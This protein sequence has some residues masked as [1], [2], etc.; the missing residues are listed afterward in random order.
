M[1]SKSAAH[2]RAGVAKTSLSGT[3][4]IAPELRLGPDDLERIH[5]R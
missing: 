4:L 2:G 3:Q 5:A 1:L